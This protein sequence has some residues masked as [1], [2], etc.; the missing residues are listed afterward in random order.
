MVP[1]RRGG[2]RSCDG[3]RRENR[4]RETGEQGREKE[5]KRDTENEGNIKRKKQKREYKLRQKKDRNEREGKKKWKKEERQ[6]EEK[7]E[8]G[9]RKQRSKKN[10]RPA[11]ASRDKTNTVGLFVCLS[12]CASKQ[13][14]THCL[15]IGILGN[16]VL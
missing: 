14:V 3:I 6:E 15:P 11:S 10:F 8:K 1:R 16:Y 9:Q 4:E 12:A 13:I 2:G 5:R 7:V